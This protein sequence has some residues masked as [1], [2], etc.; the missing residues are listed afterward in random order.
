M[1]TNIK[2]CSYLLRMRNVAD[3]SYRGNQ[4][5]YFVFKNFFSKNLTV[6]EIMWKNIVEPGRPP[7]TI[8]RMRIACW[9]PKATNTLRLCNTRCFSTATM[10]ALRRHSVT[11]YVHSVSRNFRLY[12]AM[13]GL[14]VRS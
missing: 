5:T 6:Y 13:D 3:K 10:V 4:N 8:W 1:K 7:M 11:L 14:T 2:F 9:I 12:C